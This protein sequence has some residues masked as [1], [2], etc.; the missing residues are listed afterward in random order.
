MHNSIEL[1][2]P[3]LPVP[4]YAGANLNAFRTDVTILTMIRRWNL[5]AGNRAVMV[6]A[7]AL[8]EHTYIDQRTIERGIRRLIAAR[9]IFPQAGAG[10]LANSYFVPECAIIRSAALAEIFR[11]RAARRAEPHYLFSNSSPICIDDGDRCW[12]MSQLM[13]RQRG[14]EAIPLLDKEFVINLRAPGYRRI[15]IGQHKRHDRLT[16]AQLCQLLGGAHHARLRRLLNA[17]EQLASAGRR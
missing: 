3:D 8:A 4:Y 1:P 10:R 15:R 13:D 17:A 14:I 2:R 5:Y 6:S 11:C 12:C 7:A 16:M 9:L